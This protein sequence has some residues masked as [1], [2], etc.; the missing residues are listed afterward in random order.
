MT[1]HLSS[2]QIVAL[3][4]QAG[5]QLYGGEAITQTEHALQAAWLA[6]QAGGD[7]SL[8]IACLLHDLGHML[9]QQSDDELAE[10]KDDLHQ[11]RVVPYLRGLLPPTVIE[12]IR[13]HVDAKRYLCRHQ[14]GYL[15][16]LSEAS[17]LSLALQGGVMDDSQ[18]C[19]FIDK[20]QAA[21]AIALRRCD[22]AAKVC[23]L[24]VPP[25]THYLSRLNS[26]IE[27]TAAT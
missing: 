22:D 6:E 9:F 3:F 7:D 1:K 12:T 23:G 21:L 20:P 4:E 17:R 26:M 2:D 14:P 11:L 25:L 18:A 8:V 19:A 24:V 5:T 13:L 27:K 16:G 10:G 15:A